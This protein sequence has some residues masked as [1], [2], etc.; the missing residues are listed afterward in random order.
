MIRISSFAGEIPRIIPRLLQENYAQVAQNTK[1]ENGALLPIRRGRFIT[2]MPQDVLSV[3]KAGNE[4]LGWPVRVDVEPGPVASDRLYITGDGTPKLRVDGTLYNLALPRPQNR[5]TATVNGTPD[6]QLSSTVIFSYTNVSQFDEESEPADLSIGVAWSPG[7]PVTLSGFQLPPAGRGINRQRIYR[8]QT[9]SL[10]DTTLYFVAERPATAANFAYTDTSYPMNEPLAS[11]DYNPPPDNLQGLTSLPNGMMA[12][13]VG[14]KVYFCEPYRPHAWPEK[15]IMTVDYNVVGLAAF[16]SSL[17]VMT[18]GMPYV[19]QG[20][21]PDNMVSERIEV[22]LPCV[23]AAGIVDLGYSVCYPSTKGLVTLGGGG[24]AVASENLFTQDQWQSMSPASFVAGQ[25][26][27]RYMASY[28]YTDA[29]GKAQR[30]MLIIDLSGSQPFLVRA[31]DDADAMFYELGSGKLFIVRN[32]REVYEWDAISEL[33]GEQLW[34]SKKFV[35]PTET[36]FACIMVEGEDAFSNDQRAQIEA[37][38][39]AIRAR[40]RARIEQGK[41]GGTMNDMA[42]NM[43]PLAGSLLEPV[44]SDEPTFSATVYADGR[45]VATIYHLNRVLPLPGGYMARQWEIEI[46]GNQ[47]VTGIAIAYSATEIAEGG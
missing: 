16:G 13:F 26:S 1:L 33:Y 45:A 10:G 27:G 41:T 2:T 4:W 32:K 29:L 46:R 20:T 21:A 39:A 42:L 19:M 34:R 23:T 24:A 12:A 3:Y 14:K 9:S 7:L 35:L 11:T 25:F 40:N 38:N 44:Q 47:M 18:E 17:A 36:N 22:N 37:K 15:Y 8:S 31:S 28:D 43:L 5:L 6:D 30:G